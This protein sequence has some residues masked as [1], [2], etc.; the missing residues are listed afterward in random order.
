MIERVDNRPVSAA[1]A[2]RG[3]PVSFLHLRRLMGDHGLFEHACLLEPRL[4]HGYTV[5]DNARA[6]V[7]TAGAEDP[8]AQEIFGRCLDLVRAGHTPDGWHNRMNVAG[9]WT[10]SVG[11]EDAHGR[12]L[13]G[14]GVAARHGRLDDGDANLFRP[15]SRRWGSP[16]AVSY[17]VLG[18]V[19]AL[20]NAPTA[21]EASRLLDLLL[22]L[23]PPPVDDAWPWPEARL[24]YDNARM[25]QAMLSAGLAIGDALLVE[26][27]LDLLA[28]LVGI[29]TAG[30]RFSFTPVG[31]RGPGERG[32]SFD[33]QPLEAWAMADACGLAGDITAD[34]TWLDRARMAIDW[35]RGRN[36]AGVPLYD[37]GT[38]SCFDGLESDGVN[39]NCGAESTLAA[40]GALRLRDK[41]AAST[42]AGSHPGGP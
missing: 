5:D 20:S 14:V 38:G 24:A 28:W 33:Q 42:E 19:E 30:D 8:M 7:V 39:L 23:L 3:D 4:D 13:W 27:G 15:T 41:L 17:A 12:A 11:T 6:L 40:L 10:D 21:G 9:V 37:P 32:P 16:R 18:A 22:G 36:D 35:F 2:W 25:P 34:S 29:E 1:G 26:Q 31:G